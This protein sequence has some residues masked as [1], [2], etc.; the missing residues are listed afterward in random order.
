[1]F[2]NALTM[3]SS[4]ISRCRFHSRY[5]ILSGL[6][7]GLDVRFEDPSSAFFLRERST[8]PKEHHGHA[9]QGQDEELLLSSA[10]LVALMNQ[11]RSIRS[12][13]SRQ[14]QSCFNLRKYSES[15]PRI[16]K[17]WGSWIEKDFA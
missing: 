1:M 11:A 15:I 17:L 13:T 16:T 6:S 8:K 14:F 10:R 7:H 2:C 4:L 3:F 5:L 12:R 9:H